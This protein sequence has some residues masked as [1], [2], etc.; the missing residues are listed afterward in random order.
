MHPQSHD[1]GASE[2]PGAQGSFRASRD[3]LTML[4]DLDRIGLA[5]QELHAISRDSRS[6]RRSGRQAPGQRETAAARW[7]TTERARSE[8]ASGERRGRDTNRVAGDGPDGTAP[9]LTPSAWHPAAA[10]QPGSAA[11]GPRLHAPSRRVRPPK[12]WVAAFRPATRTSISLLNAS[13][14]RRPGSL[15]RSVIYSSIYSCLRPSTF[16]PHC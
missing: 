11:P 1:R 14:Q 9:S 8:E 10:A 5:G 15:D 4:P 2:E 6:F 16:P 7:A 3:G 12:D 13:R